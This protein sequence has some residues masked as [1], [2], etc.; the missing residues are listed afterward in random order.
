MR[1]I[2]HGDMRQLREQLAGMCAMAGSSMRRASQALLTADLALAEQVI[3]D[4]AL[5]DQARRGCEDHAQ[6]VLALQAPVASDLRKVLAAIYSAEK[7]E[8]M[9][10]LA[11]HIADAARFSHPAAAIPTEMSDMFAELSRIA[12]G[13]ADRL[14]ELINHPCGEGFAELSETDQTVDALHAT[15]LTAITA[16]NWPHGVRSATSLALVSRFHER[17]ADH[18][19]SVAKRLDFVATGEIPA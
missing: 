16:P 4:D 3:S 15:I 8:R 12:A 1:E 19:V 13:M 17:F 11:A 7:I 14:G 10:D 9:G 2:F 6:S 5:L 18:T